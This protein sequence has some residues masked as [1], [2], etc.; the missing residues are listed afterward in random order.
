MAIDYSRLMA[1]QTALA[2]A[3]D[4]AALQVANAS[5]TDTKL[6]K[7]LAQEIVDRNYSPDQHGELIDLSLTVTAATIDLQTKVRFKTSFMRLAGINMIDL[8]V[9]SLVTKSGNNLEVSL[10]LDTTGSMRGTKLAALKSAAKDFVDA[11]VWSDQSQFYSKVALVPYSMGVNV[12][13]LAVSARGNITAGTCTSPGCAS[14]QFRN[15]SRPPVNPTF[16]ISTCVSER[17]GAEAFTDAPPST[18]PVGRNYASPNN[19]CLASTLRPLDRDKT[20]IK[21]AIDNLVA[22][23]STAGQVGIAW[24]WYVLSKDFGL[25]SGTGLPAR[26][27][28][29]HVNK[30]AVIM[31]DGEFNTSYCNGV[32][33][34]DSINPGSGSTNDKINCDSTNGSSPSQGLALC[35]EMKKKGITIYTIGFD[36]QADPTVQQ[37]LTN[38]ATSAGHA[39]LAATT[40]ELKDAFASIGKRVTSLRITK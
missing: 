15:A 4:A 23:G 33:A 20:A 31:T 21:A 9:K 25:W 12:G 40:Q 6:L 13:S 17:I 10:V 19:P 27:G 29:E 8:P 34:R 5:T 11:V 32:V 18:A 3:T 37:L 26:Y 38:C 28:A 14:Y 22:E 35:T 7:R 16:A 1:T 24:G 30:V 2:A 39:Y 36:V